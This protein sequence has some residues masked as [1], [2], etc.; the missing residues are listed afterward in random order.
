MGGKQNKVENKKLEFH[1]HIQFT[2]NMQKC[3]TQN[4]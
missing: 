4:K 1:H 3:A 2:A